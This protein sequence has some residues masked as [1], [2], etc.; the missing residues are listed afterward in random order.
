M[1]KFFINCKNLDE[2]KKAYKAAAMKNHPDM[3]GDTA[4]MQ[5]VNAEY[6][7]RFE[8]LKRSQNT[9]AEEDETGKTQATTEAPEDFIDI[10]NHLLH[11]DGLSVELCGRWLWI[12]GNTMKHKDELKACG[13]RWS[14]TKK[15]WS[16]HYAEDGA[17]WHKSHYSMQKIRSKYGSECFTKNTDAATLTA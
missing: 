6:E 1:T 12:G 3:G 15:L 9:A 4:T 10:I 7:A 8:V 14:S 17:R 5:A 11:M 13:C 16:W 2:L